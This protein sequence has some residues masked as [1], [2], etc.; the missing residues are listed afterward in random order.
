[1]YSFSASSVAPAVLSPLFAFTLNRYSPKATLLGWAVFC[2]FLSVV[3]LPFVQPNRRLERAGA[4]DASTT[5]ERRF[6]EKQKVTYR[7]WTQI[8]FYII[9]LTT[10]A[11]GLA[12]F[13][14][15][16][17]L[18][19]F[20]TDLGAS[21]RDASLLITYFNIVCIIAQPLCGALV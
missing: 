5:H 4:P 14:P 21:R 1:M 18:P 16:L 9:C 15:A 12:H 3:S 2:G 6:D 10:I 17:Y 19:T 7:F 8:L 13:L 11:Q 20:A